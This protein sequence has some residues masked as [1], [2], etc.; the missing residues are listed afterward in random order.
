MW[1][2]KNITH[3]S[4]KSQ[5]NV[6]IFYKRLRNLISDDDDDDDDDEMF[7]F[8][9]KCHWKSVKMIMITILFIDLLAHSVHMRVWTHIKV[10]K[11]WGG[12]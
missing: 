9:L 2:N 8:T 3:I 6:M 12:Y 7:K 4:V 1:T 5:L 10:Y 11:Y